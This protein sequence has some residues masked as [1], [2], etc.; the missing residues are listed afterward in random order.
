M[1]FVVRKDELSENPEQFLRRAGY[2]YVRDKHSDVDSFVRRLGR[3]YYPRFH[4]YI[5]EQDGHRQSEASKIIF[6]LHLDQKRPSYAGS[7]AHNAEYEGEVV[8]A[9]IKRLKDTITHNS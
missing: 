6:N 5:K 4:M 7:P 3:N 9:E 1:K 2:S 8:E